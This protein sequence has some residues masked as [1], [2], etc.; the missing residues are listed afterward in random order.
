M[1]ELD[2][3]NQL[4]RALSK[5]DS[6]DPLIQEVHVVTDAIDAAVQGDDSQLQVWRKQWPRKRSKLQQTEG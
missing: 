1:A 2:V 5:Y 3:T 6:A 4:R